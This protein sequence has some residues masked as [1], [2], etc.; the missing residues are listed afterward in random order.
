M[1]IFHF[2][3]LL[4]KTM[5]LWCSCHQTAPLLPP[6]CSYWPLSCSSPSTPPTIPY[7]WYLTHSLKIL[8]CFIVTHFY[9]DFN[10]HVDDPSNLSLLCHSSVDLIFPLISATPV[11]VILSTLWLP[12]TLPLQ[13]SIQALYSYYSSNEP[14]PQVCSPLPLLLCLQLPFL[15]KSLTH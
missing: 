6:S 9:L 13:V 10:I 7:P 11:L 4:L 15:L 12:V 8:I 1:L 5:E 14:L 3:L 2:T